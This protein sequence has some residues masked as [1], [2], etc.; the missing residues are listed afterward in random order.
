MKGR[1]RYDILLKRLELKVDIVPP[2]LLMAA[3]AIERRLGNQSHRPRRKLA[4]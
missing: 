3:A 4:V 2:S 1:R